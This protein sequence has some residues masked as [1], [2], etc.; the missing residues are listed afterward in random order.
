VYWKVRGRALHAGGRS[1]PV[2]TEGSFSCAKCPDLLA[3]YIKWQCD[4]L[5]VPSGG[6]MNGFGVVLL[7]LP[8]IAN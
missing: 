8:H 5:G 2:R 4:L 7:G 6:R 1:R 3:K